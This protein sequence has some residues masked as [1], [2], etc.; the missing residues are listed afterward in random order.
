MNAYDSG[1][2]PAVERAVRR[3]LESDG[4]AVIDLPVQRWG[5]RYSITGRNTG[6]GLALAYGPLFYHEDNGWLLRY[7]VV[8]EIGDVRQVVPLRSDALPAEVAAKLLYKVKP[9]LT[10]RLPLATRMLVN[11]G[12]GLRSFEDAMAELEHREL[13]SSH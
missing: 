10:N 2:F 4:Y 1:F 9:L 11:V 5:A 8:R 3:H 12:V 13:A 6:G 7:E